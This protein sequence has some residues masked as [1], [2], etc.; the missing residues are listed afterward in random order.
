[1]EQPAGM[2][3]HPNMPRGVMQQTPGANNAIVPFAGNQYAAAQAPGSAMVAYTGGNAM[4]GQAPT[5]A[6]YGAGNA[7]VGMAPGGSMVPY[8]SGNAMPG[9]APGNAMARQ[10][11]PEVSYDSKGKPLSNVM[12][13]RNS[14]SQPQLAL[15]QRKSKPNLEKRLKKTW[16][17]ENV[18]RDLE[19]SIHTYSRRH[20]GHSKLTSD[21]KTSSL[22]PRSAELAVL[23]KVV[24]EQQEGAKMIPAEDAANKALRGG[25]R[26]F[27][28][29]ALDEVERVVQADTT[30]A[31]TNT[32][33]WKLCG[34]AFDIP[35]L[36]R[37]KYEN[38]VS[39]GPQDVV[40]TQ[41]HSNRF[42]LD[43]I[44]DCCRRKD[45]SNPA[46]PLGALPVKLERRE[47][48]ASSM[49][50]VDA[51]K[52]EEWIRQMFSTGAPD[53][54]LQHPALWRP[55]Y[56]TAWRSKYTLV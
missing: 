6:L 36:R 43:F 20:G 54:G 52:T 47:S 14:Q 37:S 42:Q 38:G 5:M 50:S 15:A 35:A 48:S 23:D 4:A 44:R 1:M 41:T 10:M 13:R 2:M 27:I 34:D 49:S 19:S 31:V 21:K 22:G 32:F 3:P 51:D 45:G 55:D 18:M 30:G 7:I 8:G 12:L 29:Y 26:E 39:G 46:D 53:N 17:R 25:Y 40:C 11:T 33:D 9:L 16:N 28:D 56:P 24:K